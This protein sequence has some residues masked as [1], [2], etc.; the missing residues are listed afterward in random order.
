MLARTY[1]HY[2]P[3]LAIHIAVITVEIIKLWK[4][5]REVHINRG[6]YHPIGGKVSLTTNTELEALPLQIVSVL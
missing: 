1:R 2:F 5:I 6:Q 3:V 4:L